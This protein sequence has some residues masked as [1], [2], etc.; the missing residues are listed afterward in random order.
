VA[1]YLCHFEGLDSRYVGC[2]NLAT[3][4]KEG[5][6]KTMR[7]FMKWLSLMSIYS[8]AFLMVQSSSQRI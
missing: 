6:L 1:Q 8:I 3:V 5:L 7:R 4:P 2:E